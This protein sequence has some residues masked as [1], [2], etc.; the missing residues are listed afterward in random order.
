MPAYITFE[1]NPRNPSW[2]SEAA[3]ASQK[4]AKASGNTILCE[5]RAHA[6]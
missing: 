5:Q 6:K 4:R 1:E 2:K 3:S